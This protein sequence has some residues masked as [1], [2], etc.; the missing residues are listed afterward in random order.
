MTERVPVKLSFQTIPVQPADIWVRKVPDHSSLSCQP[1][2]DTWDFHVKVSIII[3]PIKFY[4][5][6]YEFLTHR[7]YKK[8]L[9]IVHTVVDFK[10]CTMWELQVMFCLG[11]CEDCSLRDS[12]SDSSEKLLQ[13]G[14]GKDSIHMILVKVEYM[15]SSTYYFVQSFCRSHEASASHEKQLSPWR[16][17][18]F[19]DMRR[20]KNWA[21]K[22][23]SWEYLSEDLSCQ[24]PGVRTCML[25][26]F[27]CI[28]FLVT[29]W[30]VVLQAP[31]SVAFSRKECWSGL[32]VL[33]QGI[34]STQGLNLHLFCLQHW[35]AG[36]LP[37]V[38]PG[39]S[40]SLLL[41]KLNSFKGCWKSAAA[42]KHDLIFV[43]VDGK[44]PQQVP[45][46]D[47]Y[48][49]VMGRFVTQL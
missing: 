20:Y 48:H 40:D 16:T 14:R 22:V 19:L 46:C 33:L 34:F 8:I 30:T 5:V 29:L 21:C 17:L 24:F 47:W 4:S 26:H 44:H 43:E 28:L 1:H 10:E 41:S 3:E 12:I 35:Q 11:Q 9:M 45:V 23:S 18:V 6:F 2:P 37:L 15:K 39:K 32:C 31:L 27:S 13:R 7:I 42:A 36:S 49:L 38:P 25:G